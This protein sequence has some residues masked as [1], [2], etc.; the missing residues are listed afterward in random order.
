MTSRNDIKVLS[1]NV[2]FGC[3]YSSPPGLFDYTSIG[4]ATECK[5]LKDTTGINQCLKNVSDFI[6]KKDYDFICL[7]EATNWKNIFDNIVMSKSNLNYL[8]HKVQVGTKPAFAD[9]VTFYDSSKFKIEYAKVGNV[10]AGTDGRPYQILFFKEI[11]SNNKIIIINVHNSHYKSGQNPHTNLSREL[12]KNLQL[13][14]DL[15]LTTNEKDIDRMSTIDITSYITTNDANFNVIMMGDFN[16]HGNSDFWRGFEPFKYVT[17]LPHTSPLKNT[18]L[19]T[20]TQPPNTCCVGTAP[21]RRFST[22]DRLYGDYVIIDQTKLAFTKQNSIPASSDFEYNATIYPTSD[23]IPI[24]AEINILAASSVAVTPVPVITTKPPPISTT[25]AIKPPPVVILASTKPITSVPVPPVPV[26]PVPVPATSIKKYKLT[27]H[28]IRTLRLLD[29]NSDPNSNP[30]LNGK[31]F[32]GDTISNTDTLICP[33]G[34][35]TPSGLVLVIN[36][37][38]PNIYGYIRP[39]YLIYNGT[40]FNPTK[41]VTLRLL[42]DIKDPNTEKVINGKKHQGDTVNTSNELVYPNGEITPNGLIFIQKEGDANV[43][44]YIKNSYLTSQVGGG[45]Y[46]KYLK[47]KA[48]YLELRKNL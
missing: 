23:H 19:S 28:P 9:M 10:A 31:Q 15:T 24:E 14:A 5:R 38:N 13:C 32:K 45:Y 21:L 36:K 39:T 25:A 26:P 7:Q 2:C 12:S 27:S 29:D 40:N 35:V 42:D 34:L 37:N 11:S 43:Y 30:I 4:L 46:E 8:H 18:K 1:W 33:N 22:D 6:I 3:M 17:F 44:G 16:D 48:K 41:T 47:Y 20:T